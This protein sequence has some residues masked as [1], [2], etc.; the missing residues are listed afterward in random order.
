M[1]LKYNFLCTLMAIMFAEVAQAKG[2][3]FQRLTICYN[4]SLEGKLTVVEIYIYHLLTETEG[5]S[6]F[7]GPETV[8]RSSVEGPQNTLLSRGV[9]Q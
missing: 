7:C 9:S 2:I 3:E 8:G 4:S 1:D 5:N 6:V